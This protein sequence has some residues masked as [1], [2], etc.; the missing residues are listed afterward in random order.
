ME[1]EKKALA[2]KR[3]HDKKYQNTSANIMFR[4]NVLESQKRSNFMNE[5][6][7]I[8]GIINA[9]VHG[10]NEMRLENRKEQLREMAH[11]SLHGNVNP[12]KFNHSEL[13]QAHAIYR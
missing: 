13:S 4:K 2:F 8:T 12:A 10:L 6:D 5:Y 7:R 1:F 3:D 11:L 9:K